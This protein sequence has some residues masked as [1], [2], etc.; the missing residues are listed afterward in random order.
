M[1]DDTD[2]TNEEFDKAFAEAEPVVVDAFRV[3]LGSSRRTFSFITTTSTAA[4]TIRRAQ[5][6]GFIAHKDAVPAAS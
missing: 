1:A 4:A 5:T 2:M 6:H 3:T